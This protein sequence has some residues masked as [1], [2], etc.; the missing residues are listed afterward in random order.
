[1]GCFEYGLF[2]FQLSEAIGKGL[3]PVFRHSSA[4]GT[5]E[6]LL[7]NMEAAPEEPLL[8]YEARAH[9]I[10]DSYASN[11]NVLLE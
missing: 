11:T 2:F 3:Q 8:P 5:G 7:P 9:D 6:S 10:S 1:M 4:V